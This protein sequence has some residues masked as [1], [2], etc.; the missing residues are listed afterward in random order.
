MDVKPEAAITIFELLMMGGVSPETCWAIKKHWNNK[1]YYTV[2]SCWFFLWDLQLG[3]WQKKQLCYSYDI[4]QLCNSYDIVQVPWT[5]MNVLKRKGNQTATIEINYLYSKYLPMRWIFLNNKQFHIVSYC[6]ENT[7]N[8]TMV[9][10]CPP[11][12]EDQSHVSVTLQSSE[13]YVNCI[14]AVNSMWTA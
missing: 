13:Q 4:V 14:M 3:K 9:E 2:A 12:L 10:L 5:P 1:F 8:C 11:E 6:T 7:I